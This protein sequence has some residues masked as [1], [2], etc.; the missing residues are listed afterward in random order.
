MICY[1]PNPLSLITEPDASR[2][3]SLVLDSGAVVEL[4]KVSA[5]SYQVQHLSSTDPQEYLTG[6]FRPGQLVDEKALFPFTGKIHP[7]RLLN[8][9]R[10]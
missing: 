8:S 9:N 7:T 10:T 1:Y 5:T 3:I 6:F 4:Q 2:F